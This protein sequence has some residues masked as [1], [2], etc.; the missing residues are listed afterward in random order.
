MEPGFKNL[1]PAAEGQ[2]LARDA[3][4]EIRAPK[5]GM[6]ILP[7]YQGLGNDG[8]FWGRAVSATRLRTAEVLRRL[9]VDRLLELLPGVAKDPEHPSRFILREVGR[10]YPRDVFHA[11]GYRRVRTRGGQLTFERQPDAT[12]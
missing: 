11:F 9:H 6:V 12:R 5:D 10:Y 1:S 3:R 2:L 7:L 4:G 8:F